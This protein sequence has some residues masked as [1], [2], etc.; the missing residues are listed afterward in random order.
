M[1]QKETPMDDPFHIDYAHDE[2]PALGKP[3]EVAEN[4]YWVR[5]PLDLTGLDHINVWLLRDGDGWTVVDCGMKS[6]SIEKLW[7]GILDDFLGGLPIRRVMVTHFHP[8]HIGMAGWLC[9]QSDAV[10]HAS[11]AEWLF[12]RMLWLH[13]HDD[14]PAWYLDFYRH[15]GLSEQA[16]EDIRT[17]GFKGFQTIVSEVPDRFVRLADGHDIT[18]AGHEWRIITGNGHS[19]EHA[20]LYSADLKV[21]ISGDQVLPR[22]TPHIGIHPSEPEANHLQEYLDSIGNYRHIPD[23]TLVLPAHGLPFR[24]IQNRLDYLQHHHDERLGLLE[25]ACAEPTR[26]LSMLKVLFGRRLRPHEAFLGISETLAHLHC[27]M[28]QGRLVREFDDDGVWVFRATRR[29]A[30]AA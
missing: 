22:I 30:D 1:K 10:F 13:E 16:I 11:Q 19:P 7:Q 17:H 4:V 15:V 26:A 12:S 9:Q 5:L 3:F 14:Q 25:A 18:I 27:L 2:P 24:G 23:D 20:C 6:E 21:M 28:F 8:D 29:R